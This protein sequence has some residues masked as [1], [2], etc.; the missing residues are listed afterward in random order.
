MCSGGYTHI[1]ANEIIGGGQIF[2]S[3]YFTS[4][5]LVVVVVW[6]VLF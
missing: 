5:M 3:R 4:F 2:R 1:H 6:V